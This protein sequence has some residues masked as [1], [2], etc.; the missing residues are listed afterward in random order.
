M[1]GGSA[2]RDGSARGT[3]DRQA[4]NHMAPSAVPV[5][6]APAVC[7]FVLSGQR[8]EELYL[9]LSL[10]AFESLTPMPLRTARSR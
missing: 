4:R 1:P 2:I 10:P 6:P 5:L 9:P 7:W 3:A 8:E